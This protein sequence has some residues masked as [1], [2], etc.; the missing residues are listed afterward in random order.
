MQTG[1]DGAALTFEAVSKRFGA[2]LAVDNV[3]LD[4]RGGGFCA[5]IGPSGCGKTTLLRIAAGFVG[6]DEGRVAI[7]GRPADH[8][9]PDRRGLGFVF[10]NYALFPT[11]TVAQNIGFALALRR[12]Q[13]AR[14]RDRVEA[15]CAMMALDGL[16]DRYPHELSG[17]QQQRVA[18]ARALAP[19]PPILLLDEPLSALDAKIRSQ[20]RGEIRRIVTE[21]GVTALYVTHD[22]E[23]ALAIADQ[24]A[25]MR[26]GRLLQSGSPMEIYLKPAHPFVAGFVGTANML[27]CRLID[28][29]AVELGG[30][31]QEV[32][33]VGQAGGGVAG[34]PARL[35]LRPEHVELLDDKAGGLT[36]VL[37]DVTFLGPTVRLTLTIGGGSTL[38]VDL[39][40]LDWLARR[41]EPGSSLG[42][43]PRPGM[44]V[45]FADGAAA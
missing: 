25:V 42:W 2:T 17:G 1:R 29:H 21:A 35:A 31:R 19:E 26:Q 28:G 18:L 14:I 34:A 40:T 41:I 39:A 44:G 7:A 16:A 38:L 4:I 11:K 13:K 3:S 8:L 5:L 37:R 24:V 15:L 43:R 30:R 33:V 9:P 22:Q 27:D 10:Q 12:L 36:G 45:A 6:A 32:L 23:E 20:L